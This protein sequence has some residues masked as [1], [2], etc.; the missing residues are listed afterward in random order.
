[1]GAF[2]ALE[3]TGRSHVAELSDPAVHL[4]EWLASRFVMALWMCPQQ[5]AFFPSSPTRTKQKTKTINFLHPAKKIITQN[6]IYQPF[7]M[8][9]FRSQKHNKLQMGKQMYHRISDGRLISLL[10]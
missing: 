7:L 3:T 6:N 4:F 9:T 8:E 10:V 2:H 1:V 5:L